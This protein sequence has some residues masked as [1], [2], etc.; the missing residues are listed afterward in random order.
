[1][2]RIAMESLTVLP[3]SEAHLSLEIT[4][5]LEKDQLIT[6]KAVLGGGHIFSWQISNIK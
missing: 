4:H 3:G 5:A 6:P 2:T 1:M